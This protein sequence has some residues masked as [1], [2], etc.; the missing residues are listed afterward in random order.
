V[1]VIRDGILLCEDCLIA[2]VNGDF[3]GLDYHY[4]SN[5]RCLTCTR[6]GTGRAPHVCPYC[7]SEAD[8]RHGPRSEADRREAEITAGLE[9]LGAHL[10]PDNDSETGRGIHDFSTRPCDC[11]GTKLHGSRH[12]FA[13]LGD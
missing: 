2:A 13:T 12:E 3:T 8:D 7:R 11:C 4:G 9:R 1:K 6:E 5:W 10:V